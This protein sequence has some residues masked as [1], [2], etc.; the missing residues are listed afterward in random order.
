MA[1]CYYCYYGSYLILI[2]KKFVKSKKIIQE[3]K[4]SQ[5][6]LRKADAYTFEY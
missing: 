1:Y 3:N 6:S 5:F 4:T 2:K